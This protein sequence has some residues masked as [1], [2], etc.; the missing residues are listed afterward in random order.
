[1]CEPMGVLHTSKL[2]HD[3]VHVVDCVSGVELVR[4]SFEPYMV[5]RLPT[6]SPWSCG[7][8]HHVTPNAGVI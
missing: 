5:H 8:T 1:M 4:M 3:V 7:A 6:M 2:A